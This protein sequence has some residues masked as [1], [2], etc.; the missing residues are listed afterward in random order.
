LRRL[1][2]RERGEGRSRQRAKS[3]ND[4]QIHA[5]V[6]L[7]AATPRQAYLEI[8]TSGAWFQ[9]CQEFIQPSRSLSD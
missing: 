6:K 4:G 1:R 8:I 5:H 3:E 9:Y 2:L 7:D